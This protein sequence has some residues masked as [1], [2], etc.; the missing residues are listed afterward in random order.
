[1]L[2][3]AAGDGERAPTDPEQLCQN[4]GSLQLVRACLELLGREGPGNHPFSAGGIRL[5]PL[6]PGSFGHVPP[7]PRET[8]KRQALPR[9]PAADGIQFLPGQP[10]GGELHRPDLHSLTGCLA[11]VFSAAGLFSELVHHPV[12][13]RAVT[14]C[15]K[16]S[17][18]FE[19]AES[20]VDLSGSPVREFRADTSSEPDRQADRKTVDQVVQLRESAPPLCFRPLQISRLR[21]QSVR[22]D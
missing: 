5:T 14:P 21:G 6:P 1:M 3:Q 11:F 4:I 8:K 18:R 2:K 19:A 16:R 9:M 17:F 12:V 10:F 22:I 7:Q 20:E 15:C 13:Q